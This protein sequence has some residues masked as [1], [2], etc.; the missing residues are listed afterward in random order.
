MERISLHK[1]DVQSLLCTASELGGVGDVES[2]SESTGGNEDFFLNTLSERF[3]RLEEFVGE[4][5]EYYVN[6]MKK[7]KAFV[8]RKKRFKEVL[9]S[10][11]SL[12]AMKSCKSK[13]DIEDNL[14][15]CQV[16]DSF[17]F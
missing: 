17:L 15:A 14:L 16:Q 11:T 3:R 1:K 7:W 8:D 6:L 2:T 5:H 10:S 13:K 12:S 4:K 9:K